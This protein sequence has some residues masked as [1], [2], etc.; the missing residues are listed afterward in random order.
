MKVFVLLS[1][2]AVAAARPEAGY[3]YN[4]PPHIHYHRDY[5]SPPQFTNIPIHHNGYG[6]GEFSF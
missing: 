3:S 6:Y 2:L 4:R 5:V 1:V